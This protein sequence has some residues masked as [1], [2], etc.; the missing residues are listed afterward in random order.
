MPESVVSVVLRQTSKILDLGH[1]LLF[2]PEA[3]CRKCAGHVV[4]S[5]F[6][7]ILAADNLRGHGKRLTASVTRHPAIAFLLQN[8]GETCLERGPLESG[9]LT[10]GSVGGQSARK[11]LTVYNVL[12]TE[13]DNNSFL[14]ECTSNLIHQGENLFFAQAEMLS[15]SVLNE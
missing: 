7:L 14:F 11:S 5:C 2:A 9:I 4:L 12:I 3:P 10:S 6:D 8:H 1:A 15:L 13:V